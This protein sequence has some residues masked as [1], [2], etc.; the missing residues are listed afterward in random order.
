MATLLARSYESAVSKPPLPAS[1]EDAGLK[2]RAALAS[3]LAAYSLLCAIIGSVMLS[4][5]TTLTWACVVARVVEQ[6]PK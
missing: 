3:L 2:H 6:N 1:T 5:G 4:A